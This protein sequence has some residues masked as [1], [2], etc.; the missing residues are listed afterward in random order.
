MDGILFDQLLI[1]M[2]D[3]HSIS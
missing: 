3:F 1:F 2:L